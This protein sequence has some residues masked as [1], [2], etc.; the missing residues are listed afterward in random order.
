MGRNPVTERAGALPALNRVKRDMRH[1]LVIVFLLLLPAGQVTADSMRCDGQLVRS[2]DRGWQV[3]RACGVPDVREQL[4][5]VQTAD[6][7]VVARHERW[8]FNMGP[9]RLVREVELQEGRVTRIRSGGYGYRTLPG[10][11]CRAREIS[12]G[13]SRLELLGRCGEPDIRETLPPRRVV[14]H[15]RYGYGRVIGPDR[16]EWV[17][18]FRPGGL[19]RVVTLEGGEV[20]RVET[21][22]RRN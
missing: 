21:L 15:G 22:S 10:G 1:A 8:Y 3:E 2:G 17:Y 5:T 14:K 20:T 4:E 19:P 18:E 11:P 7:T 9:Q 12:R 16:E 6:G 13:M